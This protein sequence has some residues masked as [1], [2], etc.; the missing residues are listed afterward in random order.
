M[1]SGIIYR[2]IIT[3]LNGKVGL[4]SAFSLCS[5]GLSVGFVVPICENKKR[6]YD[7]K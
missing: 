6:F 7:E 1:H 3:D 2:S 4:R 5:E